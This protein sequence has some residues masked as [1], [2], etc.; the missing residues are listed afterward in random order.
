MKYKITEGGGSV[1]LAEE[2]A[3]KNLMLTA[4]L[5]C[6]AFATEAQAQYYYS[7]PRYY[8]RGPIFYN[9]NM[10]LNEAMYNTRRFYN[11][12]GARAFINGGGYNLGYYGY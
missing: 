3:M 1:P 6:L 5:I 9:A 7:N 2:Q 10:Y 4:A 12:N 11:F 8:Y